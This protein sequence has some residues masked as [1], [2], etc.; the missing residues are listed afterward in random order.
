M[1]EISNNDIKRLKEK[2]YRLTEFAIIN[3][4]V[5]RLRNVDGICYFYNRTN[6]KCEIY[7]KRPTGCYLYP[8][9]YMVNEGIMVD[10]L[11]PMGHT[12]SEEELRIKGKIL[13]NFLKKI[14]GE[15]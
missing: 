11:C 9:V 13:E 10:E 12:I 5:T 3:D 1:M 15:V 7:E 2:G 6:Q 8:V 4:G 14:D